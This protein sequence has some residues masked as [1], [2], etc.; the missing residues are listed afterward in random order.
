MNCGVIAMLRG[1]RMRMLR[2]VSCSVVLDTWK[3]RSP[4]VARARADK[5]NQPGENSPEQRQKY[6][7][8]IHPAVSPSSD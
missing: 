7:R 8:L 2:N 3:W 5:R 6:D 4:G 1:R